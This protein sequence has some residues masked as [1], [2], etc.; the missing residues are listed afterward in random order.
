MI[1]WIRKGANPIILLWVFITIVII[2]CNSFFRIND[3][4]SFPQHGH[5]EDFD[6]VTQF[7]KDSSKVFLYRLY[8]VLDFVWAFLLLS[9][10]GFLIREMDAKSI[11]FG[12]NR[13]LS[14][15]QIY[16]ICAVLA[17]IFDVIEGVCYLFYLGKYLKIIVSI[18]VIFYILCFAFFLYWALKKYVFSDFKSLFRFV[19]T[20]GLSLV[21]IVLIYALLTAMPQGGTLIVHLFYSPL[22]IIF[23]F[24]LLTFLA[25][26]ISHYPVYVDIWL[27][28]DNKSVELKMAKH[29]IRFLGFGIIYYNTLK[30]KKARK[31]GFN[32]KRVNALRRS[33]GVFL[34]VAVFNI[35]LRV[36]SQF[37]EIDFNINGLTALI[38]VI[39]LVIYN[40]MGEEYIR[41]KSVIQDDDIDIEQKRLVVLKIVK[42]VGGFPRYFIFSTTLV[43]IT[44]LISFFSQW[45]RISLCLLVV[46]LA[47]QMFLYTYFKICRTYFKYIFYSDKLKAFNPEM[48]NPDTEALFKQYNPKPNRGKSW[49]FRQYGKLSDNVQYLKLMQFSGYVALFVVILANAI[50]DFASYLNPLNIILLYIVLIYSIII[51]TFKHVLYYHRNKVDTSSIYQEFFS[52]GIPIF[53]VM[54]GI[55]LGY[56]LSIKNDLH[57]LKLVEKKETPL[58]QSA[59]LRSMT[60][61]NGQSKKNNYFFVGSYGGGLKANLWNLLI[62][63]ELEKNNEK[64]F[65]SRTIAMSGVSGGAVGIGNFAALTYENKAQKEV[66]SLIFEIGNS[67]VLSNEL[68][69]LLGKDLVREHL[70]YFSYQGTDRSYKSMEHHAKLTGMKERYNTLSYTDYWL[71]MYRARKGKFPALIMNTTSTSGKQGVASTVTFSENT[72]PAADDILDFNGNLSSKTLTYFGAVSTTNRFPLFSPTAKIVSKGSYL[73][74]GYFENSGMLS[75]LELYDAIAGDRSK[76]YNRQI[77]PVFINIINSEDYYIAKKVLNDWNFKKRSL[78]EAGEISSILETVVSIDKLPRYVYDKIQKRGFIIEPIMMPHKITYAKVKAVLGADVDD[79]IR[80]MKFIKQ[81]NDT[82]NS[83]L[84]VYEPYDYK[85]WGVVQPPLARVLSEPSVRYQEAMVKNH[86]YILETIQRINEYVKSDEILDIN[87]QENLKQRPKRDYLKKG[88][89]RKIDSKKPNSKIKLE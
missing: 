89:L 58:K 38:L 63:N 13:R 2:I 81:H 87:V 72:F 24:F 10:I 62:F 20:S 42:Y 30:T 22:N 60:N 17:F 36:A 6:A 69:Y 67:N 19:I 12:K 68:V 1:N 25:I 77:N 73:D 82:I 26:M 29:G 15:F 74:G 66:D 50:F 83:V 59:F 76:P 48:F 44:A 37:F 55:W 53:T 7:I 56:N 23:F 46:T 28:G 65:L 31:H 64:A 11:S 61:G 71:Q 35:F 27:N 32:N 40:N 54:F 34:Y 88:E 52:Y 57:E 5:F 8:F 3:Y 16:A 49:Y 78:S 9:I 33:L 45:S 70:P 14:L 4:V 47:F 41:W 51:I 86:P 79:P 21:F 43:F 80:L 85:K 75:V 39:T 84:K 18:K